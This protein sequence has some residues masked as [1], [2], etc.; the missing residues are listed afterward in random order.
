MGPLRDSRHIFAQIPRQAFRQL[1]IRLL[2]PDVQYSSLAESDMSRGDQC[3]HTDKQKRQAEY[4][5][6]R[7]EHHGVP[8]GRAWAAVNKETGGGK[9]AGVAVANEPAAPRRARAQGWRY[10][11]GEASGKW[12]KRAAAT[13]KRKVAHE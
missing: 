2:E 5:E 6:E 11:F 4:I 3:S 13:R 8:E 9:R 7:Y 10:R 12:T 1:A